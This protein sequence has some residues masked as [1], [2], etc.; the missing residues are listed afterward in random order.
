MS[1]DPRAG[2]KKRLTYDE[3][4][5]MLEQE[6]Q[7]VPGVVDAAS[8]AINNPLFVRLKEQAETTSN[9]TVLA[10]H[11]RQINIRNLSINEDLNRADLEAI[12]HHLNL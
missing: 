5:Q 1:K 8:R 6:P 12:F 2:L 11:T 3:A 7:Y 4:A 9:T 10:E